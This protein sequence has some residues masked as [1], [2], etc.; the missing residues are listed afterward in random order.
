MDESGWLKFSMPPSVAL[1]AVI[2]AAGLV[3][4]QLEQ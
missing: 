4:E 2:W 1:P 3:L